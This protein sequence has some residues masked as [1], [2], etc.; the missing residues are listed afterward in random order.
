MAIALGDFE[1]LCGFV[2]TSELVQI[3]NSNK[4]LCECIQRELIFQFNNAD[5]SQIKSVN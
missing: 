5:P 4:E 1:A 2:S 3:F